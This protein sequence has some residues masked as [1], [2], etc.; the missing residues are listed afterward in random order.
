MPSIWSMLEVIIG[1][2]YK[3]RQVQMA[4]NDVVIVRIVINLE[5][6]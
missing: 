3:F 5:L 1:D 2:V 6:P 4:T